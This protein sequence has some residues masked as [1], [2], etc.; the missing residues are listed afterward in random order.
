[1]NVNE[2]HRSRL[3]ERFEKEGLDSFAPHNVLELLLFFTI[4]RKDTNPI[5]HA[6]LNKFG[7]LS[8]VLDADIKSLMQVEGVGPRSAQFLKI[9]PA[10]AR[11]YV[12]DK[13]TGSP[14][15]TV[16]SIGRHFLPYYV[17]RN[18]ETVFILCLDAKRK[19]ICTLML[20]QG[21]FSSVDINMRKLV[22][23]AL[24]NNSNE[25]VIAH[26]HPGGV[27]LPSADDIAA[28]K[29]I[30]K[31]LAEIDIRLLDHFIIADN[32]YISLASSGII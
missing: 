21:N 9:I 23:I 10:V 7:S 11:R 19:E 20:H 6:L 17:G 2:G 29:R 8:G 26:N 14:L 22:S 5:A 4:P 1:M 31:T 28:T 32:D 12:V 25:I 15:A 3:L 27:A 24:S 18:E 13:H 16:D 30:R